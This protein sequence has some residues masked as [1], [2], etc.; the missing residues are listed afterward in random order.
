MDEQERRDQ[1]FIAEQLRLGLGR[2]DADLAA[3]VADAREAV[4]MLSDALAALSNLHAQTVERREHLE[5]QLAARLD[6]HQQGIEELQHALN[7]QRRALEV[8]TRVLDE[9]QQRR[10]DDQQRRLDAQEEFLIQEQRAI[11]EAQKAALAEIEERLGE[12]EA[13]ARRALDALAVEPR[14]RD[15]ATAAAAARDAREA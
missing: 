5:A 15:D 12:A 8:Q 11:V 6:T 14:A 2:F 13:A 4:F 9:Q 10:L 7:D 1:E 3:S